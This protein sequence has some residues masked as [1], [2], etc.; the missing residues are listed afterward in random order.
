MVFGAG[1]GGGP[2][3]RVFDGASGIQMASFFA[4]DP[5]FTGGVFVAAANGRIVVGAGPGGGPHVKVI[6]A[7][8]MNQIQ[9]NGQIADSALLACFY[10]FDPSFTGGVQVAAGDVSGDGV[11]DVV[12]GAGPGGGAHVKVIDGTRMNEVQP[13]GVIA[14]SAQW[15][16]FIAFDLGFHGGVYVAAMDGRFA[17]GA[18]AGGGPQVK[19]FDEQAREQ[20]NFF[21]F[22]P[23]FTG[24][25]RVALTDV[26]AD[27]HPDLIAAA[28]P[29][30]GPHVKAFNLAPLTEIESMFVGDGIDHSGVFVA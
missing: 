7:A 13:T 14:E 19:V 22:D 28:G 4:F 5:A 11:S 9:T 2:H 17:V 18:G 25:V 20:E 16:N 8:R 12:V 6:D 23:A 30:G 21:A 10:A 3:V 15:A 29:G 26:N 24:G 27:R 1:P